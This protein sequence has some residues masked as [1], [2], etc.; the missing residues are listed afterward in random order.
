MLA[1]EIPAGKPA[2]LFATYKNILSTF[3]MYRLRVRRKYDKRSRLLACY[4]CKC[5]FVFGIHSRYFEIDSNSWVGPWGLPHR[6]RHGETLKLAFLFPPGWVR[7]SVTVE[8]DGIEYA[9]I[10]RSDPGKKKK[11]K[12]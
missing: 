1:A 2:L 12:L 10:D 5:F 3:D 4:A 8:L 11:V 7:S 9:P 6:M